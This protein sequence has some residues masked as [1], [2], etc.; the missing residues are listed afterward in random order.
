MTERIDWLPTITAEGAM[1]MAVDEV[2]LERAGQGHS[3]FRVYYWSETTLSLGYFQQAA[4]RL[5]YPELA[6]L[7]FVRRLTGGGAI[8][9]G[10]SV[11]WPTGEMLRECTY[12]LALPATVVAQKPAACWHDEVHEALCEI[13]CQNGVLANM[14]PRATSCRREADDDTSVPQRNPIAPTPRSGTPFLCFAEPAP[15]DIVWQG[16]KIVGSAQRLRRSALLQHGSILLPVSLGNIETLVF[17][18]L[19]TLGFAVEPAPWRDED[20]QRARSLAETRYARDSW[21]LRR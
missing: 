4:E 11:T 21:N 15:G 19:D 3:S 6:A 18:W 5:Q 9:H 13:L 12:A 20:W 16:R 8:V 17:P 1:Q 14:V 10:Q 2:L 7:P